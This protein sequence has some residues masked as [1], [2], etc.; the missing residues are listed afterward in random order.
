M[1]NR[2]TNDPAKDA[3]V[4]FDTETYLIRDGLIAPPVVCL[5]WASSDGGLDL[6]GKADA[7]D[8]FRRNIARPD[9]N[10]V[11]HNTAYDM[12]VLL[13]EAP[14]T[15]PHVF[16]AYLEGRVHDTM[17]RES[18]LLNAT[19]DFN[20]RN[21]SLAALVKKYLNRDRSAQK[22]GPD[23]W[24]L[25]YAELDGIP[26]DQWP[27]AARSYALDDAADTLRV[28]VAQA[29]EPV[30]VFAS[31]RRSNLVLEDGGI[32]NEIA[33]VQA[34]LALQLMTVYGLHVDQEAA[35]ALQAEYQAEAD[36][37]ALQLTATGLRRPDGSTDKAAVKA[38]I[39]AA[40]T[41]DADETQKAAHVQRVADAERAFHDSEAALVEA[42]EK[43]KKA[44]N[45]T[46]TRAHK[47]TVAAWKS[48]GFDIPTTPSGGVKTG[49]E[50][51][52]TIQDDDIEL[53]VACGKAEK[54]LSTYLEPM[55][56]AGDNA[57]CPGYGVL[58]RS[59]RTSSFSPN[60]QNFPRK[61]GERECFVPRP[62]FLFV[63]ADYST[64]EL[65]SWAQVCLDLGLPSEMA[66]ALQ[67]G[68][69]LHA[70][71]GAQLLGWTYPYMMEALD[72]LHGP[73]K[74][75][76]AKAY[77]SVS[78]PAN[79]GLPVGM[80]AQKFEESAR[81]SYGINFEE[82]GL[83]PSVPRDAWYERWTEAYPYFD[84]VKGLLVVVGTEEVVLEDGTIEYRDI[85]KC[86]IRHPRSGRVRGG[87]FFTDAANSYFQGMA[88]DGAKEALFRVALECYADPSSPLFG[89]RPVAFIHDEI[90]MEAPLDRVQAGAAR[91]SQVM[92]EAMDK[93]IPDIPIVC[94]ADIMDRWAKGAESKRLEDGTLTV[95]WT[96]VER[97][98]AEAR[99]AEDIDRARLLNLEADELEAQL[100]ATV[101]G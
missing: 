46:A 76:Q 7:L 26:V 77:R 9:L 72:G 88:A 35:Q 19:G 62:G 15:T 27:D 85:R 3:L 84:H 86:V 56:S 16:K 99:D 71:L 47:A 28:A 78:K 2:Q 44:G 75:A 39:I 49:E 93:F 17:I 69:D 59:G 12:V 14:D 54:R 87:C 48:L 20:N 45:W 24:R 55:T 50:I 94:E 90:I 32:V 51:L 91:L 79:F 25:R 22:S 60:I 57:L 36:A 64:L 73:E 67:Q 18:L 68:R 34:A 52:E 8:W 1:K 89:C 37:L 31:G 29:R 42:G 97:L 11:G 74:K 10:W 53:L 58:K 30:W 95:Y 92:I 23:V 98:R 82:I 81:K 40:L 4:A 70:D 6:L 38:R 21:P 83:D 61:G 96:D 80:G 5:S 63:A 33:Q 43:K 66:K 100:N 65:R 41:K 101:K 13:N